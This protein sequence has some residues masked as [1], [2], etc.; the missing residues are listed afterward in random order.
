MQIIPITSLVVRARQRREIKPVPLHSLK[1][2]IL[3]R[4]LIQPPVAWFDEAENVHVLS[5]GERRLRA[6]Q[7]LQKDGLSFHCNGRTIEPGQL[8]ILSLADFLDAAGRF[9]AEL[10]ENLQREDIEWQDRARALAQLHE[11]RQVANPAQTLTATAKELVERQAATQNPNYTSPAAA[12]IGIQ[13]AVIVSRE[14]HDPKIAAARNVHEAYQLVLLRDENAVRA[15]IAR[16]ENAALPTK[17]AIEIRHADATVFLP[18]LTEPI[19]DLILADPP[20]GIEAGGGGFRSRTVHHHNYA[21]DVATAKSLAQTIL[22]EGFRLTKPRANLFLFCHPRLWNWLHDAA[23]NM[24]WTPFPAP[25]VWQKSETEGLAPWGREGFR[26]TYE[27]LL[28]ATKGQKGLYSSPVDIISSKRVPRHERTHAAEKPVELL[29]L[30]IE[31]STLRG[32]FVLD[33][34]CGS[35]S[36]LVAARELGRRGLGIEQ[37]ESYYNLALASVHSQQEA[38]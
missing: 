32:D 10:D 30:L 31:C 36:S 20:Y 28:Y 12:R 17:P 27:T 34:C 19:V 1:E 21:D 35:G 6:V 14:L 8:P 18:Q 4:G 2:S 29:K 9:E 23:L 37:D 15:A 33:P 25:I 22:T 5:V 16:R 3:G 13:Q 38:S 26:R 11:M 24:G 7:L